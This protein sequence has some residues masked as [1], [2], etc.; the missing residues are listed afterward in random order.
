MRT[1]WSRSALGTTKT[2]RPERQMSRFRTCQTKRSWLT[3]TTLAFANYRT[4]EAQNRCPGTR[5]S[6]T[7][8]ASRRPSQD[9]RRGGG[10]FFLSA[11]Q[12]LVCRAPLS[13]SW[14]AANGGSVCFRGFRKLEIKRKRRC[15]VGHVDVAPIRGGRCGDI[16]RKVC[17]GAGFLRDWRGVGNRLDIVRQN[18]EAPPRSSIRAARN[19][20]TR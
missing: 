3:V 16:L 9:P 8:Q 19:G 5:A 17:A 10:V 13:W 6:R 7:G 18:K 20:R 4:I 2:E 11:P 12:S 1:R 14:A 15:G